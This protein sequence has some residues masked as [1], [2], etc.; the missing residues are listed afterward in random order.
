[1]ATSRALSQ[2]EEDSVMSGIFRNFG[3]VLRHAE[4]I[5]QGLQTIINIAARAENRAGRIVSMP[6]DLEFALRVPDPD[7]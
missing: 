6:V 2:T 3:V 1:M 4:C 5:E 7:R